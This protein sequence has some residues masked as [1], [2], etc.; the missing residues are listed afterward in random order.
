MTARFGPSAEARAFLADPS[1]R[2]TRR[3]NA[4]ELPALR[5]EQLAEAERVQP[6]LVARH[7]VSLDWQEIGDVPCLVI[8]PQEREGTAQI[9][10]LFGGAF[11]VGGPIE[12]LTLSAA[13]AAQTGLQVISPAYA[14]APEHPFPVGLNNVLSV[15]ETIRPSAIAGESA[16]GNFGLSVTRHLVG[17]GQAPDA[18]A[19]LSP[20]ADLTPD[21]DPFSAPDDPTL[22]PPFVAELTPAYA[23]GHDPFDDR[24]SP[25]YGTFG[26]DWP[27]T[28]ITTGTRDLFLPQCAQLARRMRACQVKT[29]LRVWDGLWH[30]FEY[31]DGIPEGAASLREIAHFLKENLHA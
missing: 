12:D 29:D 13:L 1:N 16:G 24:I 3:Y 5:A 4:E 10:Y 11:I 17:L 30:V 2:D 8:T 14:L 6:D 7:K 22:F 28:L 9:L 18:L 26:P 27:S 31:Y 19:L 20:A 23:P 25:L 15:A 21:F